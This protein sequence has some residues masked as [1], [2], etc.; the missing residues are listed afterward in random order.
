[1]QQNVR[2]GRYIKLVQGENLILKSIEKSP[3]SYELIR[4]ETGIPRTSL[5]GLL[6]GLERK[7]KIK[8]L[9]KDNIQER[10]R[11]GIKDMDG[12]KVFYVKAEDAAYYAIQTEII[13][14]IS[15]FLEALSNPNTNK[16]RLSDRQVQIYIDEL[17]DGLSEELRESLDVDDLFKL[18]RIAEDGKD[19]IRDETKRTKLLSESLEALIGKTSKE[20]VKSVEFRDYVTKKIS[21]HLKSLIDNT[22]AQ[23]LESETEVVSK[24]LVILG[25]IGYE[26]LENVICFIVHIE[27]KDS[28]GGVLTNV[29]DIQSE[30]RNKIDPNQIFWIIQKSSHYRDKQFS[31]Y[32]NQLIKGNVDRMFRK[33]V[34]VADSNPKLA[35]MLKKIRNIAKNIPLR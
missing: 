4:K 28:G 15:D 26:F 33:E 24:L 20:K 10:T 16:L 1:M 18:Y 13:G 6:N 23:K 31:P 7:G 8:R 5:A 29:L 35:E 9:G 21:A 2:R 3:K 14:K 17:V 25:N 32:L 19:L 12:R 30:E 34:R 11:F 22:D 27:G